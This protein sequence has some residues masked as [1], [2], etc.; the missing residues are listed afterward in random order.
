M[1]CSINQSINQSSSKEEK[2]VYSSF[3]DVVRNSKQDI[4]IHCS[5]LDANRNAPILAIQ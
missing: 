2:R 3:V 1:L 5:L 4:V